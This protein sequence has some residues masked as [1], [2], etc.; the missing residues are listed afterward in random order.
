[1]LY[2]MMSLL[3]PNFSCFVEAQTATQTL[4]LFLWTRPTSRLINDLN[5]KAEDQIILSIY[6]GG[7]AGS[8][9]RLSSRP[10]GGPPSVF[11][12]ARAATRVN[13]QAARWR[14]V[15]HSSTPSQYFGPPLPHFISEAS[16]YPPNRPF[17]LIAEVQ[18]VCPLRSLWIPA[19]LLYHISIQENTKYSWVKPSR[20]DSTL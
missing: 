9:G 19:L 12:Y 3:H 5:L 18:V 16:S 13:M 14:H 17:V 15:W 2:L 1:M 10:N 20:L 8:R 6:P 11:S 7:R 4:I